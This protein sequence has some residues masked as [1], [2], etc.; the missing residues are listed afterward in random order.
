M[1]TAYRLLEKD[2]SLKV[3]LVEKEGKVAAHQTGHNSGV[4]HSGIYYKPGSLKAQNCIQGYHDLLEF[5]KKHNI[6]HDLCGKIIVAT[7]QSE[8]A[9]MDKVMERGIANGLEGLNLAK[10]EDF[11]LVVTDIEMPRMSGFELT[12]KI[13]E[14]IDLADMPVILV[15]TLDSDQD[16]QRGMEAGAN[17]FIVK[18]SFEKSN[19]VDTINRLI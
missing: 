13:R 9:A 18:S 17:A 12:S 11:D 3:L 6:P 10:S 2:P 15:T 5:A 14:D 7:T 1:A 16:K 4:I 8:V 19:L